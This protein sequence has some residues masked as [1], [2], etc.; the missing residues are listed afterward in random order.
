MLDAN[1]IDYYETPPG[2]WGISSPG[3]W[4]RDSDD[5][6]RAKVLLDAYQE[7]RYRTQRQAYEQESRAGHS[8][9]LL[10][11]IIHDPIRFIVYLAIVA[12]ILYFSIKPFF[13][14][15]R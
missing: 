15:G 8:K 5:L 10:H 14:L 4:V 3:I 12:V 9:T 2:K 6:P 11:V 1:R 7:E 13:S